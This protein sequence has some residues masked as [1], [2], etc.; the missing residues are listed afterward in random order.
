MTNVI[1]EEMVE[2]PMLEELGGDDSKNM[3]ED[4]KL[5]KLE[6][7]HKKRLQTILMNQELSKKTTLI[8]NPM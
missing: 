3:E 5:E 6:G 8:G 4:Y 2:N 7:D 1:A